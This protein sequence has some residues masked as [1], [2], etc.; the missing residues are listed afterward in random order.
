[1]TR[2]CEDCS[3]MVCGMS[4]SQTL[5]IYCLGTSEEPMRGDVDLQTLLFLSSIELPDLFEGVFVFQ[6]HVNGPFSERIFEDV[7]A[8]IKD[9]Y[10]SGSDFKLSNE[11]KEIYKEIE[12]HIEE[13]LKSTIQKNIEFVSG[14]TKQ[15]LQTFIYAT[16][17]DY[18][19]DS[20]VRMKI[21]RNRVKNAISMLM[22]EKITASQ[23][24]KVAGMGYDEF[25]NH[26]NTLKIR[27]KS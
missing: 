26:L 12:K 6:Q 20:E 3:Q 23:A 27:W 22:K 2:S 9:G 24:A 11:G 10:T 4:A 25:E 21:Q 14:L 17:P 19:V 15:E 16:F 7:T 8:I 5:V 18:I 1:M 13:P